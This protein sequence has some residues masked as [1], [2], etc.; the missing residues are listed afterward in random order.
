LRVAPQGTQ[1]PAIAISNGNVEMLQYLA[2]LTGTRAVTTRQ[3]YVKAGCSEHC[4]EK[5]Q[6]VMS[7]SGRWSVT[8]AKATVVLWNIRPYIHLQTEAVQTALVVG[9][10]AGFKPATARM[11]E[12]VGWPGLRLA[13]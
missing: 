7:V 6:H 11:G 13:R 8:G 4:R 5:H 1:L 3:Q 12:V 10:G 2:K 9:L